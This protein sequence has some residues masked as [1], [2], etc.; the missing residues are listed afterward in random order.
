[1]R[2]NW[3]PVCLWA[4][5]SPK[6]VDRNGF[7]Q[8]NT[9]TQPGQYT[10][11]LRPSMPATKAAAHLSTEVVLFNGQRNFAQLLAE[12]GQVGLGVAD[13]RGVDPGHVCRTDGDTEVRD[14][15]VAARE[16]DARCLPWI[17]RRAPFPEP[18]CTQ[19]VRKR[20]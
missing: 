1:M 3:S 9:P 4:R 11:S 8:R 2:A 6:L 5:E 19:Q 16:R 15:R 20:S 10:R 17:C 13:Q 14:P 7:S 12:C 18:P